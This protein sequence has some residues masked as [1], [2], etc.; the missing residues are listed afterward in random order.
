MGHLI[1]VI[2]L[3]IQCIHPFCACRV[4]L[5]LHDLSCSGP[6]LQS[7]PDVL[8]SVVETGEVHVGVNVL[9]VVVLLGRLDRLNTDGDTFSAF[10]YLGAPSFG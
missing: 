1:L 7:L 8:V 5:L 2:R 4:D 3:V 9:V 10:A 6:G